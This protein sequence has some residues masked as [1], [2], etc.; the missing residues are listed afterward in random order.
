M[1]VYYLP[2]RQDTAATPELPLTASRWSVFRARTHRAWWRLRLTLT[3]IKSVIRRG[4]P[5]NPLESHIWFAA[6]DAPAPVRRRAAG[7]AR[8]LDFEAA[9]RRRSLAAASV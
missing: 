8:V 5:R 1:N 2:S 9:R 3:E 4:G 7:P 6:E